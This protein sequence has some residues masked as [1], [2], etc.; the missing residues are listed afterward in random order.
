VSDS[1]LFEPFRGE[2][3]ADPRSLSRRLAPPYDVVAPELRARLARQ[4][5]ANIVHVD[6][7]LQGGSGDP[8]AEAARLLGEW[9]SNG[10]LA[11]EA[12][13][14][15]YVLR[16]SS[17][18]EDGRLRQRT[19]VF[20]ALAA[21]PYGAGRV[22]PHERTHQ[23]PK[24][25]R[26]RLTHATAT[27]LSPIFVLAPDPGGELASLLAA[28]ACEPPWAR[29]EAMGASH[30]AWVVPG[31]RAR[32]IAAAASVASCYIAD[33]HHRYETSVVISDE[34]PAA[35]REGARRTLAYAVSFRDPG[36]EILPTHRIVEG[37]PLSREALAQA[38]GR[39]FAP[40]ARKEDASLTL[41]TADGAEL[42]LLPRAD[43]DLAS[44]GD[45]PAHPAV[46]GLAVTLC[47]A[48][49]V[50]AVLGPLLRGAPELRYTP[51]AAEARAAARG[52]GVACAVLLPATRLEE[53][54][55]VS[56]A[57][58]V[59]PPKSTY[60]APKVPTGVVLR[61]LEAV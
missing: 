29:A 37:R 5:P 31:E 55:A 28:V 23:G 49:M 47:D 33:G 22:K 26:R 52:G 56:D 35:W 1:P 46:R 53:V 10:V 38:A 3:Y 36:L 16:T 24:E 57:G 45:L 58:E 4:D 40:A 27:N 2:R 13:S 11:R 25:D 59:M 6:L 43:A 50:K 20:L 21:E 30:E 41:V 7:P 32:R 17:R 34:A 48:V 14:A 12:E 9:R 18:L 60:F 42:P 39:Y 44:V 51:V 61:P 8:Y 19:G 54:K 15:A